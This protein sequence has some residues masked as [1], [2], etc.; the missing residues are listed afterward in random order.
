MPVVLRVRHRVDLGKKR[1]RLDVAVLVV[2]P[3]VQLELGPVGRERSR[4]GLEVL[5]ERHDGKATR[6]GYGI[7]RPFT[8]QSV[9]P[10]LIPTKARP[11]GVRPL[12]AVADSGK[13]IW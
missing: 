13:A 2:D 7:I 9:A 11:A 4:H 8:R 3:Q 10:V 6:P 12:G 5:G 1:G